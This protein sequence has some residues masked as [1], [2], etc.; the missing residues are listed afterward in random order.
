[1]PQTPEPALPADAAAQPTTPPTTAAEAPA[2]AGVVAETLAEPTLECMA[3]PV[4]G[5]DVVD[6]PDVPDVPDVADG[7]DVTDVAV[8]AAP[9]A[10]AASKPADLDPAACAALLKKS[11]PALFTGAPKPIKLRIQ[12]DIQ[13]RMPGVFSKPALS[14]FLRRYTGSTSYLIALTRAKTRFDLDGQA[15]GELSAEHRDAAVQELERR[16]SLQHER[17]AQEDAERQQRAALLRAFETT[18]LTPANFCALKGI[19]PAA[20]E[21]LLDL[22]R[23]ER[24]AAPPPPLREDHRPDFSGRE[25]RPGRD[26]GGPRGPGDP[27]GPQ[28]RPDQRPGPR[29]PGAPGGPRGPGAPHGPGDPGDGPRPARRDGDRPP[30]GPRAP[31]P[32]RPPRG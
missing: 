19:E 2:A 13:A 28:G 30:Q 24:A 22:A 9:V 29:G 5:G 3:V 16:R 18:T 14:G 10:P 26:M 15:D 17:R 32:P 12:A 20:L 1:M 8:A 23:R 31:R 6:V 25:G 21:G 11:F 7:A 4:T 27:R